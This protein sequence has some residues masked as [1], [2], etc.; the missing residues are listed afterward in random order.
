MQFHQ[1]VGQ[2]A[3]KQ[4]LTEA[5]RNGRLPHALLLRG[6]AGAGKLALANA[7]IQY[8]NCQQA[9][10]HDSC[11]RCSNCLRISKGVFPD[12]HFVMPILLRTEAGRSSLSE[13]YYATF[14]ERFFPNPYF[15]M[16][17]WQ[18]VLESENRQLAIG[19]ADIRELK[20]KL[21]LRAFE[22]G[23]KAAILWNAEHI[24][25][26]AAN[27]FLKLLEEPPEKTL[28]IL[29]CSDVSQLLP[30]ILSRCQQISLS[31][32]SRAD[33]E[34]YLLD[35][36]IEAARAAEAAAISEGSVSQ[37]LACLDESQQLMHDRYAAWF[38]AVYLG[39]YARIQEEIQPVT[40]SSR[41]FQKLFLAYAIKK[42]RDSLMFHAGVEELSLSTENDRSFHQNF[43]KVLDVEKAG[44]MV[45]LLDECRREVAGNANPQLAFSALSL[46]LYGALRS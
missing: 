27:A 16:E 22:G 18:Q 17:Q 19:V 31:R 42:I 1:I 40:E 14:R 34:A 6:P 21:S 32:V 13:D 45:R 43:A 3:A 36:G 5:A 25:S 4:Q 24:R 26:E 38:R 28:L 8:V 2:T 9:T 10:E 33:I 35:K 41:E 29:T 37:A 44:N 15:S 7:L 12:L 46:R 20:R 39:N 23:Y 30:T 11:G